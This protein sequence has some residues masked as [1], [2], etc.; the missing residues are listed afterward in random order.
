MRQIPNLIVT[1]SLT[2][3]NR[4]IR[5]SM[6]VYS[7]RRRWMNARNEEWGSHSRLLLLSRCP[8]HTYFE[9]L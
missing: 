6:K 1:R 4:R 3:M 2:L 5:C 8:A 9:V 7:W